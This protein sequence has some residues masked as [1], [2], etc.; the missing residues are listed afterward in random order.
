MK[1]AIIFSLVLSV[2]IVFNSVAEENATDY[3]FHMNNYSGHT[4]T[5]GYMKEFAESSDSEKKRTSFIKS[6][7]AG[8]I[9]PTVFISYGFI[10]HKYK[11]LKQLDISTNNE[12]REHIVKKYTVDDYTQYVPAIAVYGLQLTGMKPKHNLRD[13]TFVM[14]SSCLI[15]SG[16]VMTLKNISKIER[17]DSSNFHSF[18]S[19]H[20]ATAFTGA[21]I[22]FREYKDISPWI[23]VM[24]YAVAGFTGGMRVYNRKHWISDVVAGAGFGI[25]SA[26]IGFLLLPVFQNIVERKEKKNIPVFVPVINNRDYGVAMSYTF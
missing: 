26:E 3:S 21:H 2:A 25:M 17:P 23:G 5:E 9:L 24:G 4:G 6:P 10:A 15:M 20:T 11:P 12:I 16:C 14:A 18:P 22:L 8:F 19:G 1:R 7:V 13:R